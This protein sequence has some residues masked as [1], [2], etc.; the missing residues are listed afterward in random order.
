REDIKDRVFTMVGRVPG[1]DWVREFLASQPKIVTC[2]GR[3]LDP[4]RAQ[5]F[6]RQTVYK[7]FDELE[8]TMLK[9]KIPIENVYNFDE[10]G[11]Q[12]GGGRKNCSCQYI[13]AKGDMNHYVM[14]S[15]NLQLVTILEAASA[16]GVMVPPG[17]VLPKGEM[18]HWGDVEGVG[19]VT[20]SET[21]WTDD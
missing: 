20:V 8:E 11:V 19:C 21:G 3:G 12:L 17:I 7:Y 10:K 14:K 1:D 16:D 9:Y 18:P 2:A 13:F 15:D 4:K 5:A 6:N